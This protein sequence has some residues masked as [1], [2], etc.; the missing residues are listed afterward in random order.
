VGATEIAL[1]CWVGSAP[2][3]GTFNP[4]WKHLV[5]CAVEYQPPASNWPRLQVHHCPLDD[6]GSPMTDQERKLAL[7]MG[8]RASRLIARREGCLFTCAQGL[9]RSSLVASLALLPLL[10]LP[11]R[12]VIGL[13]R[14]A[15]GPRAL[16][17]PDFVRLLEGQAQN[18]ALM[19]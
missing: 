3:A 2:P 15:R 10:G 4:E 8:R 6:D 14:H 5:L 19:A 7:A 17:N 12:A 1:H 13:V 16:R 9:N 18:Q 11:P